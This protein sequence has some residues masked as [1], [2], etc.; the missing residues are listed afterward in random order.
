MEQPLAPHS[1]PAVGLGSIVTRLEANEQA[2]TALKAER[3]KLLAE[4][5]DLAAYESQIATGTEAHIPVGARGNLALRA[6]RAEIATALH[7]SERTADR[8]LSDAYTLTRDFPAVFQA[9][10]YGEISYQH[11]RVICERGVVVGTREDVDSLVRRGEY[12]EH[13][14]EGAGEITPAALSARAKRIAEH[15]AETPLQDRHEEECRERMV[16]VEERENGMADLFAHLPAVQA[17]AIKDRLTL[18]AVGVEQAEAD[19]ARQATGSGE[20]RDNVRSRCRDEI[21]ADVFTDLLL[22]RGDT[23]GTGDTGESG[24]TG[25]TVAERGPVR[26]VVQVLV[27][28]N[29]LAVPELEGYGPI[30]I[31]SVRE[32][33][34]D[35]DSWDLITN[36]RTSGEVISVDRYRPSERMRRILRARDRHCRFPG[37]RVPATRCDIDHT[38]DWAEGGSTTTANLAHLCRGHH[39]LK[40][41]TGW[42]VQQEPGGVLAWTSPTG[43]TRKTNP[44]GHTPSRLR[45]EPA[46]ESPLIN[47]SSPG[48]AGQSEDANSPDSAAPQPEPIPF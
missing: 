25:D 37:C 11:A 29:D 35:A 41:Q 40:H 12:S 5:F 8:H 23:G 4:A 6:I 17:Y 28:A 46:G 39:T 27:G 9:F 31:D 26:A 24:D 42:Q 48:G 45:F 18:L 13:V 47:L 14:L 30:D 16:W 43:R 38:E 19:R 20:A 44:P 21:R 36:G 34:A 15:Y 7:I 10:Q 33:A 22:G 3:V 2:M 1:L 32:L